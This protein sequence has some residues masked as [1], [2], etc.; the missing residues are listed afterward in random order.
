V[1]VSRQECAAALY[2][3]SN[4]LCRESHYC[5]FVVLSSSSDSFHSLLVEAFVCSALPLRYSSVTF[6]RFPH[7]HPLHPPL[8]PPVTIHPCWILITLFGSLG[9][10]I[11]QMCFS[12]WARLLPVFISNVPYYDSLSIFIIQYN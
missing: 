6:L 11:R 4:R 8:P 7:L 2:F 9:L 10:Y 12:F 3:Y 1:R 5:M